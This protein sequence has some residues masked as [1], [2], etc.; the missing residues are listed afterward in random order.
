MRYVKYDPITGRI[1]SILNE[2]GEYTAP[3][4]EELV[5]QFQSRPKTMLLYTVRDGVVVEN[6]DSL[7]DATIVPVVT[8]APVL[9]KWPMWQSPVDPDSED[10]IA[11]A[12][13]KDDSSLH[14]HMMKGG[15]IDRTVYVTDISEDC[16]ILCVLPK[17]FATKQKLVNV[18][19]VNIWSL[20]DTKGVY[21]VTPEMFNRVVERAK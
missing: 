18:R 11:I 8:A 16:W 15:E 17:I 7:T 13:V 4:S 21:K 6:A 14:I 3:V 1:I 9:G 12:T 19:D 10:V 5:T 2:E 20:N